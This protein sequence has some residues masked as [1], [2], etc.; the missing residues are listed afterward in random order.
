MSKNQES[1]KNVVSI[2][3]VDE[4]AIGWILI[5]VLP[6]NGEVQKRGNLTDD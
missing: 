3:V 4:E 5:Q 1:R 2:V 6:S